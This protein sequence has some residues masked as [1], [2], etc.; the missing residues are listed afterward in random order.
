MSDFAS[1]YKAQTG[2][3]LSGDEA[4]SF[5]AEI[6][7]ATNATR[8]EVESALRILG[9]EMVDNPS[10]HAPTAPKIIRIIR[11]SRAGK[12]VAAGSEAFEEAVCAIAG[13]PDPNIRW[14]MICNRG[15]SDSLIA[16]LDRNGIT[17][18][19]WDKS[20]PD[21]EW[22]CALFMDQDWRAICA[23]LRNKHLGPPP[24]NETAGEYL[25]RKDG[26]S[27]AYH[28]AFASQVQ[29]RAKEGWTPP[30]MPPADSVKNRA[31]R[32]ILE[33]LFAAPAIPEPPK[34]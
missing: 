21:W 30:P 31:A 34:G 15:A 29:K 10:A 24:P 6:R 26:H 11:Q 14:A 9:A 12:A 22:S 19:R 7:A 2:R 28:G 1:M 18:A 17:Y 8:A 13:E 27:R 4:K 32:L 20:N 25:Q 5:A 16:T 3:T 33:L 23:T